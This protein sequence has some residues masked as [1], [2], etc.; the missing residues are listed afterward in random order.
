MT[1]SDTSGEPCLPSLGCPRGQRQ[2]V[3]TSEIQEKDEDYRIRF[4]AESSWK[5][6]VEGKQEG[7]WGEEVGFAAEI[8]RY[9]DL[10]RRRGERI[11]KD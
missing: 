2:L 4:R 6:P 9:E 5:H 8:R 1:V 3:F 7:G 11:P 10:A